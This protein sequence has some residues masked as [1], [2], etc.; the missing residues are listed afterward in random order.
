MKTFFPMLFSPQFYQHLFLSVHG[1]GS[2]GSPSIHVI[3]LWSGRLQQLCSGY[4]SVA[5][6]VVGHHTILGHCVKY[7]SI[8]PLLDF[9]EEADQKLGLWTK[10]VSQKCDLNEME[11][12]VASSHF[13]ESK[14]KFSRKE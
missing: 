4:I 14:Y 9:N 2:C 10:I 6:I 3:V 5:T 1:S 12:F 13:R 7:C 8:P 11:Y